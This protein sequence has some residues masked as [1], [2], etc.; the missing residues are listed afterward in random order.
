M[1]LPI[2]PTAAT[3]FHRLHPDINIT[4]SG[5]GSGVG[6]DDPAHR[7]YLPRPHPQCQHA[8]AMPRTASLSQALESMPMA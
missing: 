6:I 3:A 8:A 7:R 4:V 2:T 1:S 5:G